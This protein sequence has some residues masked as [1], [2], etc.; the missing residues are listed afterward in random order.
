MS[1]SVPARVDVVIAGGGLAGLVAA[2]ELD[3]AGY[4]TVVCEAAEEV[5]GRTINQKVG[6]HTLH[7]GASFVGRQ[8]KQY[9]DLI[10]R[11]GCSLVLNPANH[12]KAR[13]HYQGHHEHGYLPELGLGDTLRALYLFL[14]MSWLAFFVPVDEPW[15]AR[16]AK[17]H[18]AISLAAWLDQHKCTGKLRHVITASAEGT[19]AARESDI[20]FLFA[21]WLV[22]R[23]HSRHVPRNVIGLF[24]WLFLMF[25]A[26]LF[27]A[28]RARLLRGPGN[29]L[30]IF[31]NATNMWV[32]EGT[33]ELSVRL[34]RSL[35][36]GS[37][38]LDA[39]IHT[40]RQ[41]DDGV[42]LETGDGRRFSGRYGV[43]A[44]PMP[45]LKKLRFEPAPPEPIQALIA[46]LRYGRVCKVNIVRHGY[47]LSEPEF[48]FGAAN[49]PFGWHRYNLMVGLCPASDSDLPPEELV[50]SLGRAELFD[51]T[52]AG[53][54]RLTLSEAFEYTKVQNW[55]EAPFAGGAY[56]NFWPG[57]LTV[58]G[59][60][61]A[62]P[63][64][65]VLFAGSERSSWPNF[66]A[67]AVESGY[68]TA[69][70]LKRLL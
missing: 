63:H 60:H 61:L 55:N 23:S 41:T 29:P 70:K 12:S 36:H 19:L 48:H 46:E 28:L 8:Q 24:V 42:E 9:I 1:T 10:H 32:R 25:W 39:P 34:A 51:D 5:G 3:R 35:K 56:I 33:Q 59:P 65:R 67:G 40:V 7:L 2:A 54:Q 52:A 15:R 26:I 53:G 21:L 13:W 27:Q 45:Q 6:Q 11:L 64:G 49:V 50:R 31:V 17:A 20:S 37:V 43:L 68:A 57:Q 22:S 47:P 14:K 44:I 18:D 66:M 62:S 69:E 58:H 30:E 38:V 4:K 16:R